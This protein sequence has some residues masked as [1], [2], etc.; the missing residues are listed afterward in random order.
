MRISQTGD[1]GI[2]QSVDRALALLEAL[3]EHSGGAGLSDLSRAIGLPTSTAHRLLTTLQL[4][5]FVAHEPLSRRWVI[6][7]RA[8][9]VGESFS[10]YANIVALARPFL[11][12]LRDD[13]RE[14]A[15]LGVVEAEDTV[16]IAQAESREINRAIAPPGG[17]V[18]IFNSGMGKAIIATWPDDA[19]ETL[20]RRQSLRPMTPTSLRC[21]E[22]VM[23]EI[24][25]TRDR[26]Y[27]IDNEE[28][29][30]GMRCV[31]AVVWSSGGDPVAAVS[32]SGVA[33]R[34]TVDR[35]GAIADR[36]RRTA[37]DLTAALSGGARP[38]EG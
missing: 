19:I 35:I 13:T 17:R 25:A 33:G 18:P 2:V 22:D 38:A 32:V 31:A 4:R 23:V 9:S 30:S 11:R 3:A 26:G 6:G 21:M 15:N 16:T 28:Y 36:V 12:A 7:H 24:R 5:G 8:F 14:T 37:L 1:A 29:I 20:V 27:A 34:V 10:H